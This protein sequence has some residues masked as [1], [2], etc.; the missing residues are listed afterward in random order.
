MM[1]M[2]GPNGGVILEDGTPMPAQRDSFIIDPEVE[3]QRLWIESARELIDWLEEHPELIDT[4]YGISRTTYITEYD[5][6]DVDN[7]KTKLGFLARRLGV[8]TKR[9]TNYGIDLVRNFGPHRVQVTAQ[10][11]LVCTRR[12]VEVETI[13]EEIPD[14]ALVAE[15]PKVKQVKT[16]EKVEWDC[17]PSVLALGEQA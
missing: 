12:V 7:A 15:L 4:T 14:P 10:H 11:E 1:T 13:E 16:V 2:T 6:K 17:P 8:F 3:K 5:T 9:S